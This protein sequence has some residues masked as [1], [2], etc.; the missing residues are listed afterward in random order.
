VIDEFTDYV[1]A[2]LTHN[3]KRG[4]APAKASPR[5]MHNDRRVIEP[6]KERSRAELRSA[7]LA[8][9][10]LALEHPGLVNDSQRERWLAEVLEMMGLQEIG[11]RSKDEGQSCW[12][13]N[14]TRRGYNMHLRTY[15]RPC[16]ACDDAHRTDLD[17][18][19]S[20]LGITNGGDVKWT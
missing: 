5:E 17:A 7:Q 13:Y 14:G 8:L 6:A 9:A 10:A 3:Q 16:S 19:M 15:T 20:A 11:E 12:P 18:E 4:Y 1:A 2:K